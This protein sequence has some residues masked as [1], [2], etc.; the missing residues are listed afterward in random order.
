M[1]VFRFGKVV[2]SRGPGLNLV[3]P[4]IERLLIVDTRMVTM[5]VETKEA[6]TYDDAVVSISAVFMFE[7]VEAASF[8][9]KVADAYQ[10]TAEAAEVVLCE[11]A[12]EKPLSELQTD[13]R[14]YKQKV[15]VLLDKKIKTWGIKT[16]DLEVKNLMLIAEN[17]S[18]KELHLHVEHVPMPVDYFAN[19]NEY[20]KQPT[21]VVVPGFDG[22]LAQSYDF[23]GVALQGTVDSYS[24]SADALQES[25]QLQLDGTVGVIDAG[26]AGNGASNVVNGAENGNSGGRESEQ[27]NDATAGNQ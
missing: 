15:R 4:V 8:V 9:T 1:V 11:A 21:S 20:L 13:T 5:P 3:L 6:V 22:D 2:G 19:T 16:S 18:S 12:R 23:G 26:D 10:A 7:V 17:R 14:R 25:V 27:S 24:F